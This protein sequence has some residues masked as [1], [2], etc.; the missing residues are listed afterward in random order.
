MSASP[1]GVYSLTSVRHPGT[2]RDPANYQLIPADSLKIGGTLLEKRVTVEGIG[3][4]V[5]A[6][7]REEKKDFRQGVHRRS[8]STAVRP[9]LCAS[10]VVARSWHFS[11]HSSTKQV[12]LGKHTYPLAADLTTA[13]AVG[14]IRERPQKLAPPAHAASGKIQRDGAADPPAGLRPQP[15]P[16]HLRARAA[17]HAGLVGADDQRLARGSCRFAIVTSSGSTATRAAI[18]FPY[19]AALFRKELDAVSRAFPSRNGIILV[20]HSMGGLLSRLMVTERGRKDLAGLLRQTA[21]RDR[22][23]GARASSC[24]R[25]P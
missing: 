5:V 25:T 14:L 10:R 17:G 6:I 20:G 12:S 7:G 1:G 19:S 16:G 9:G 21:G 2:D 22:P 11:S 18:R 4:P 23:A 8:G 24:C 15:H 13:A 3:A